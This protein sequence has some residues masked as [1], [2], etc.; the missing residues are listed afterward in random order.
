ME[1]RESIL[2]ISS[3]KFVVII[4]ILLLLLLLT[5]FELSL[6]G[7]TPYTR[8]DKTNKNKYT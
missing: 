7:S 1:F 5:A 6:G 2:T 3:P 4:I 8:I